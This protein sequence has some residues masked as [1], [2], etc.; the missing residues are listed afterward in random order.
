MSGKIIEEL[1]FLGNC[2]VIGAILIAIYDVLRIWR[3][4]C[5]H[6]TIW[7]AIEDFLYWCMTAVVI[8]RF[9]CEKNNGIMRGFAIGGILIGMFLVNTWVSPH[10][11]HGIARFLRFCIRLIARPFAA[12][13]KKAAC[14]RQ[15]WK[16]SME[17]HQ[18]KYH[19]EHRKKYYGKHQEKHHEKTS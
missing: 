17:K 11:V 4:V 6:G 9:L 3:L 7:T 16:K 1:V 13:V 2:V 18:E 5:R 15:R 8:F 14:C 12:A 19:E 10:T